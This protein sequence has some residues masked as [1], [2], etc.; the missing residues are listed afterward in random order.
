MEKLI[1]NFD[2]AWDVSCSVIFYFNDLLLI[3]FLQFIC[4]DGSVFTLLTDCEASRYRVVNI[5][6][7]SPEK[8]SQV[9]P[10]ICHF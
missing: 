6:I 7:T 2:S 1:D 9:R 8:V 4:N 10:Y 5:E 3:T